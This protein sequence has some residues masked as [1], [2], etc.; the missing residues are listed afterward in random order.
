MALLAFHEQVLLERNAGLGIIWSH[1]IVDTMTICA[2]WFI[3]WLIGIILFEHFHSCTM[4][5]GH[6]GIQHIGGYAILLHDRFIG[7]AFRAKLRSA[8][9]E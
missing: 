5:I 3:G 6:I 7:M 2:N 1:N 8:I 9:A 4:E